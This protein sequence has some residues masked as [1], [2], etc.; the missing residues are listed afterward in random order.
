MRASVATLP[1][2]LRLF[3]CFKVERLKRQSRAPNGEV[4]M[5]A[6]LTTNVGWNKRSGPTKPTTYAK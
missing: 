2:R 5:N 4:I 3:K 6:I 1:R